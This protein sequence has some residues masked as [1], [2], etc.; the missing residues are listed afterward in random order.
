[1]INNYQSTRR[2]IPEDS[3]SSTVPLLTQNLPSSR[4][5]SASIPD[6][7]ISGLYPA[8]MFSSHFI[9]DCRAAKLRPELRTNLQ[10]SQTLLS[11][12]SAIRPRH[13]L[14]PLFLLS[15][16][17]WHSVMRRYIL[18]Q[19]ALLAVKLYLI[20]PPLRPPFFKHPSDTKTLARHTAITKQNQVN[21][22]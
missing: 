16:V 11:I 4:F 22:R 1:M 7:C 3:F 19:T 8:A 10:T 5:T 21:T 12:A 6:T 20:V 17:T 14:S 9:P 2:H 18:S 13:C 15:S